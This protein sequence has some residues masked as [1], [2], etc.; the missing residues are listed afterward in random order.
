MAVIYDPEGFREELSSLRLY[1]KRV[2]DEISSAL[3]N[4]QPET[5]HLQPERLTS[6]VAEYRRATKLISILEEVESAIVDREH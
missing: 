4:G 5:R 3:P 1:R 6:L 2:S